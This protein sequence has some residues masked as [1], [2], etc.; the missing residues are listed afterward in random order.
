MWVFSVDLLNPIKDMKSVINE[1]C[2]CQFTKAY[3]RYH[4]SEEQGLR[5]IQIKKNVKDSEKYSDFLNHLCKIDFS[6]LDVEY[7]ENLSFARFILKEI[8]VKFPFSKE[9]HEC[10]ILLTV[11]NLGIALIT[12][13]VHIEQELSTEQIAKLQ[14]IPT[15]DLMPVLIEIPNEIL[16]EISE[17]SVPIKK[18]YKKTLAKGEKS[19]IFKYLNFRVLIE[20]FW[21][22][23]IN[24]LNDRKYKSLSLKGFYFFIKKDVRYDLFNNFPLVIIH[25]TN[26]EYE[27]TDELLDVYPKQLYQ[28]LSHIYKFDY[29]L[30]NSAVIDDILNQI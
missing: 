15:E 1:I 24:V 13:W 22:S 9:F 27:I 17:I 28:I 26:P 23:L 19:R 30:I 14:I 20:M 21:F 5:D 11:S 12:L 4:T 25:S 10:K 16:E 18:L 2:K 3:L 29:D 6:T 8:K 7:I